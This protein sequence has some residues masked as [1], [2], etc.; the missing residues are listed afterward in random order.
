MVEKSEALRNVVEDGGAGNSD[1]GTWY[2]LSCSAGSSL[3]KFA[4]NTLSAD[5]YLVGSRV[6]NISSDV[7]LS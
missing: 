1:A 5:V 7:Y 4:Y 2:F 3:R 6:I